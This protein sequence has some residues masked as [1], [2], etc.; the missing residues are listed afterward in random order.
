M[1]SGFHVTSPAKNNLTTFES[2]TV[3]LLHSLCLNMVDGCIFSALGDQNFQ[4]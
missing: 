4:L 2:S 1:A 3:L